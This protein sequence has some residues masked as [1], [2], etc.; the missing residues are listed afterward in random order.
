MSDAHPPPSEPPDPQ[1]PPAVPPGYGGY[2]PPPPSY[3]GG[4]PPPP[5]PGGYAYGYPQGGPPG[6]QPYSVGAAF[7]WGW[8]K[9]QQNVGQILIAAIAYFLASAILVVVW[10]LIVG[11]IFTSSTTYDSSTGTFHTSGT[12]GFL[13]VLLVGALY[14]LLILILS[15]IWQA[16]IIRGAS[17]ISHGR[18]VAWSTMLSFDNI[19]SVIVAA[20]I[21]GVAIAI[22]SFF[23]FLPGIVIAFY[24]Q[25]TLWFVVERKMS[26][27]DAIGASASLVNKN[28]GSLI[29]FY[30]ASLVAFFVGALLCGVGLLVA[31][32]V[33]VLAQAF[34]YRSLKGEAVTP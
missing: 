13:G 8:V 27:I 26:P 32:P 23:C 19:G 18:Q 21:T 4:Y 9:F 31:F 10:F 17:E 20:L 29:G 12:H 28:V 25:F 5:P 3:P 14:T 33:V 7:N 11:A 2:P 22:G 6:P 24:T 30:L 1:E 15:S 16:G 34:T